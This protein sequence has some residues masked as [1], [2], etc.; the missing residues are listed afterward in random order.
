M[1]CLVIEVALAY[2]RRRLSSTQAPLM[3]DPDAAPFNRLP[4]LVVALA[5]VLAGVE[6]MFF[7]GERGMI[8]TDATRQFAIRD[9]GWNDAIFHWMIDNSRFPLSEMRRLITYPFLHSDA[10]HAVLVVVF[11]L[12][13]GKQV[14]EVFGQ[15]S[16]AI[17]FAASSVAGAL[18]MALITNSSAWLIGG[19]PGAYGLIGA[20]THLLYYGGVSGRWAGRQ[21][22]SLI[23][24]LASLG[25]LFSLLNGEFGRLTAEL[26]GFACGFTL[27]FVLRPGGLRDLLERMRRR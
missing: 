19:Y 13:L 21:A 22:F 27:S 24:I 23:A 8:A 14:A 5:V 20:F 1:D 4:P 9:F 7:L 16:F 6:A 2:A 15:L 12:A 26:S 25:L 3:Q 17:I 10:M 11:V 18:G